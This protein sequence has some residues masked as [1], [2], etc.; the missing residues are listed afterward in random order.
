[1]RVE[2]ELVAGRPTRLE[3]AGVSYRVNDTPTRLEPPDLPFGITHPPVLAPGW[4]FQA[5]GLDGRA[6]VFDVIQ[7]DT[8]WRLVGVYD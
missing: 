7:L 1:M 4:R 5:V 6:R 3:H 8:E 2:V